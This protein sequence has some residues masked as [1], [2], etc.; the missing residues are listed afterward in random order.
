MS[1]TAKNMR[2][3]ILNAA[4]AALKSYPTDIEMCTRSFVAALSG[5]MAYHGEFAIEQ[6]LDK[7][8]GIPAA[9]GKTTDGA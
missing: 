5:S 2:A 9:G 3:L 4:D 6:A 8:C 1:A 7:V